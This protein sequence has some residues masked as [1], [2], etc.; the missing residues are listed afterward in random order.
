[1]IQTLYVCALEKAMRDLITRING[2]IR[3]SIRT[4][5]FQKVCQRLNIDDLPPTALTA[6]NAYV[7]G[8]FDHGTIAIGVSYATEENKKM[9]SIEG[10]TLRLLKSRGSTLV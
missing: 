10:K 1:M 6:N 4:I 7:S 3:H 5:P 2:N 9:A 8:L